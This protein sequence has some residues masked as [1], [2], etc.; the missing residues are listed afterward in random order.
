M[1]KS[2]DYH[3]RD[4]LWLLPC[5]F[6]FAFLFCEKSRGQIA[7]EFTTAPSSGA[8]RK[9]LSHDSDDFS[10]STAPQDN[11]RLLNPAEVEEEYAVA[12]HA[13]K[14]RDW[15]KAL[16]ALEMIAA[17]DSAYRDVNEMIFAARQGMEQDSVEAL[18]AKHYV[19]GL[20]AKRAGNYVLALQAFRTA[21]ELQSDFRDVP[22]QLAELESILT[23]RQKTE[24]AP[25]AVIEVRLDSLYEAARAASA[26]G[27]WKEAMAVL[28]RLE[29]L[30]PENQELRKQAEQARIN[31]MI[32]Q[33]GLARVEAAE[34]KRR[35]CQL[36]L[37]LFGMLA[38]LA[39][40][41]FAF[42]SRGRAQYFIMRGKSRRAEQV[43]ESMLQRSPN[44][45]RAYPLLA[46]LYLRSQRTDAAAMKVFR[47]VLDLNLPTSERE[48][49][50]TVVENNVR[51]QTTNQEA[52]MEE[53]DFIVQEEHKLDESK[54]KG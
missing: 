6:I 15:V 41:G 33:T 39:L 30:D 43:Y 53:L 46:Q 29:E 13:F 17:S 22:A 12:R 5:I 3:K 35:I 42:S 27:A 24:A 21:F 50:A 31:F 52:A 40:L 38:V 11:N 1:T 44:R 20:Q 18:A 47:L 14:S 9:Q 49:I 36:A 51:S 26:R 7:N 8:E 32:A 2:E 34:N 16:V 54:K 45:L 48:K 19:E 25:V 4:Q 10:T 28:S 37:L 23:G